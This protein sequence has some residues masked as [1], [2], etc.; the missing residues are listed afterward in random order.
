MSGSVNTQSQLAY[1]ADRANQYIAENKGT[2]NP[3]YRNRYHA[4]PPVGWMNDPNGF[5]QFQGAYHLFYQFHPYDAKWGPLHWGHMKSTDLIHWED[6][7]VALAP[8][9]AYDRSGCFSG[10]AIERDGKLYLLYTG[11]TEA[12][13]EG[14]HHQVQCLAVSEDGVNFEKVQQNPVIPVAALPADASQIDFRD[15]KVFEHEGMYYTVVAS[16]AGDETG[17][18]LLYQSADLVEWEFA[19][20]FL[21]GNKEQGIM[22]ECP[23]FFRLNGKDCLIFSPM[24]WPQDGDDYQNLNAS[25]LAVG[26]VDWATKQ[27]HP[28]SYQELDHG[29]DYYAPQS[30]EDDKGRRICIGW[31]QMWGRNFP[32][33][34]LGHNWTGSM[35]IPRELKWEDGKLKQYPIGIEAIADNQGE[36]SPVITMV[37]TKESI[38]GIA[39]DCG[40]L[41]L[42]V[43][44]SGLEKLSIHLRENENERTVVYYDKAKNELGID[45]SASGIELKGEEAHPPVS[46]KVALSGK[47]DHLELAIYLDSSSV[48]V[49]EKN[50]EVVMTSNV[51]PTAEAKGISFE[52]SGKAVFEEATFTPFI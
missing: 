37:D 19:S 26:E 34:T 4:S 42:K 16:K 8:D 24:Q 13:E 10:S 29:L 48:E 15:P 39:G 40:L 12:N 36:N 23:D 49:F 32:T 5:V 35:T 51:Y 31:M 6:L 46:R 44:T 9:Q 21:K 41:T 2:V 52:C 25:V 20:V 47:S 22:W 7:P 38:P 50:G 11:V 28:E 30:L 27:F 43:D 17:Q 3:L 33:D 18:I 1:S 45:R 14:V